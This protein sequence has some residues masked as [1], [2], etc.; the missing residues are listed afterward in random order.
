MLI[1]SKPRSI[2]YRFIIPPDPFILIDKKAT[3][4]T[5]IAATC[6]AIADLVCCASIYIKH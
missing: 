6:E 5:T 2:H 4:T 3:P 1:S